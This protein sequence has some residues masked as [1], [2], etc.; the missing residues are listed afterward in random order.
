[1]PLQNADL[2]GGAEGYLAR[3]SESYWDMLQVMM[4]MMMM[5]MIMMMVMVTMMIMMMVMMMMLLLLLLRYHIACGR[6][7]SSSPP[8]CSSTSALRFPRCPSLVLATFFQNPQPLS[9]LMIWVKVHEFKA[10]HTP[11]TLC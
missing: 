10:S 2:I 5:I 11:Q 4:M 1:M 6:P 9:N 3:F 7:L 8:S